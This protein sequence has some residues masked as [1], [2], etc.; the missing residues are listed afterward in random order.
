MH[1]MKGEMLNLDLGQ[2]SLVTVQELQLTSNK[3]M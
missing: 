2:V 3:A 1:Y